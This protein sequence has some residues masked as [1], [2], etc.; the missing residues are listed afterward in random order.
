MVCFV[1]TPEIHC[2]KEC[3]RY[4]LRELNCA[5]TMMPP[6]ICD[7]G[8]ECERCREATDASG[9]LSRDRAAHRH[10]GG[11]RHPEA[12]HRFGSGACDGGIAAPA[13]FPETFGPF[14]GSSLPSRSGAGSSRRSMRARPR[15]STSDP[16]THRR[17]RQKTGVPECRAT[18][19]GMEGC[20]ICGWETELRGRA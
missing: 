4:R 8:F 19:N 6:S 18:I 2:G 14:R 12:T 16:E 7:E 5:W 3:V 13:A 15:G 10:V 1:L 9:R 11:W 20:R 17:G